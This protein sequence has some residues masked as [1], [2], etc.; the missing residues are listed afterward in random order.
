METL[1]V[2]SIDCQTVMVEV[3]LGQ[4]LDV[5]VPAPQVRRLLGAL[6]GAGLKQDLQSET[7]H[8][9]SIDCQTVVL[10][11]QLEQHLQLLVPAAGEA[12]V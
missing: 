9:D 4:R 5:L 6:F 3:Q 2:C 11:V 7:L 1:H 8:S 10:E 12:F